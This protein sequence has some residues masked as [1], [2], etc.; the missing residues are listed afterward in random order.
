M[1]LSRYEQFSSAISTIYHHI[2][3]IEREEMVRCS[4]KGAFAQYLA[5]LYRCPAGLTSAQLSECCDRDKAAVSRA[6]AEMEAQ[7]LI[8]RDGGGENLYRARL[9]LT[10]AGR[11]AAEFVR[12]RAEAAV[13]AGGN[14]LTEEARA[15]MYASLALIAHNLETICKEGLHDDE[16]AL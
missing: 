1:M 14:G 13:A 11:E 9:V 2:Q 5:A 4:G 12:R 6:V 7:G 10:A 16:S 15:S 3:R 8:V